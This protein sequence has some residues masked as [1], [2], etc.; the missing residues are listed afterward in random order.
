M[1]Q[2]L[3]HDNDNIKCLNLSFLKMKTSHQVLYEFRHFLKILS[4]CW[5]FSKILKIKFSCFLEIIC[6]QQLNEICLNPNPSKS[7]ILFCRE[8]CPLRPP[9]AGQ[10][11]HVSIYSTMILDA[12]TFSLQHP[13]PSSY[14]PSVINTPFILYHVMRYGKHIRI[15]IHTIIIMHF[16]SRDDSHGL[17]K[18]VIWFVRNS[19]SVP[20]MIVKQI[21]TQ[22]CKEQTRSEKW[23]LNWVSK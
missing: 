22:A 5:K 11:H 7:W 16:V 20:F 17:L 10:I 21:L 14:T 13:I 12:I 9:P 3:Y 19:K 8:L 4:E 1:L 15:N 18:T 2:S 6:T 23:K